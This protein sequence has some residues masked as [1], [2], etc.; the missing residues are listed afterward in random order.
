[1]LKLVDYS[2][3]AVHYGA[4]DALRDALLKLQEED[5]EFDEVVILLSSDKGEGDIHQFQ[6]K[7]KNKDAHFLLVRAAH[8]MLHEHDVGD[9]GR[10]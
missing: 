4:E 6:A 10:G 9:V 1:M 8:L 5:N 3:D 7:L 2:N